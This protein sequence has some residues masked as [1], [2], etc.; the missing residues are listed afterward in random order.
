[1][2]KLAIPILIIG[3]GVV[4]LLDAL[5][6][7]L[8]LGFVWTCVLFAIGVAILVGTGVNKEGFPWGMFFLA[9]GTCSILRQAHILPMRV[10]LPLLVIVLGVP[11]GISQTSLIPPRQK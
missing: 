11:L 5:D 10:E 6:V 2:T 8:P 1:M 7:T 3:F 4:W 9:A